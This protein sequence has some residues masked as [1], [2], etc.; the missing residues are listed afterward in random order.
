MLWFHRTAGDSYINLKFET[1]RSYRNF[2][3]PFFPNNQ[4]YHTV[5]SYYVLCVLLLRSDHK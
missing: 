4:A 5:A 2:Y 3:I 1:C